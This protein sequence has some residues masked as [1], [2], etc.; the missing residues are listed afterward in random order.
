MK[1]VLVDQGQVTLVTD[2]QDI[3]VEDVLALF[4]HA[5]WAKHRTAG[6]VRRML[7]HTQVMVVAKCHAR[8]VGCARVVTDGAFR[9]FVEDVVVI[10]EYR[11]AGIGR[12]MINKLEQTV[13][14]M[15]ITR[16]D[17]TTTQAGFWERLGYRQKV[18]SSYM[19]KLLSVS[20]RS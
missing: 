4:A 8:L 3:R 13:R 17:L 10:P 14:V 5:E 20:C 1:R 9:A 12:L 7:D 15:G 2:P 18:G 19:V 6:E 16:L 11:G